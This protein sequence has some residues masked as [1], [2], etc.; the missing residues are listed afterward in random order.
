MYLHS[1]VPVDLHFVVRITKWPLKSDKHS[2]IS[3]SQTEK[4]V[5][6]LDVSGQS[7]EH[8]HIRVY[9]VIY[10]AQYLHVTQIPFRQER[11]TMPQKT[12]HESQ[13]AHQGKAPENSTS[14]LPLTEEN[15]LLPFVCNFQQ[16]LE[17]KRQD[18]VQNLCAIKNHNFS[19]D[20][21]QRLSAAASSL[22]THLNKPPN[23]FGDPEISLCVCV[24]VCVCVREREREKRIQLSTCAVAAVGYLPTKGLSSGY[25]NFFHPVGCREPFVTAGAW[26]PVVGGGLCCVMGAGER[27]TTLT[28]SWAAQQLWQQGGKSLTHFLFF[29]SFLFASHFMLPCSPFVF[30]WICNDYHYYYYYYFY[31]SHSICRSLPIVGCLKWILIHHPFLS[32]YEDGSPGKRS[33]C[34]HEG[35]CGGGSLQFQVE[36]NVFALLFAF[37]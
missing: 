28:M 2:H 23:P 3:H 19:L 20:S 14:S 12:R 18:Q 21:D 1:L 30:P 4:C 13:S 31:S 8:R 34:F 26:H 33:P 6:T 29:A 22:K 5:K 7:L 36:K 25:P 16:I 37:P 11:K 24:C 17:R 9:G 10:N 27:R 35:I 15:T 32:S